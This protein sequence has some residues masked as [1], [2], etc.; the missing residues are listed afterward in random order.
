MRKVLSL[1]SLTL[2]RRQTIRSA[3]LSTFSFLTF[4]SSLHPFSP[5][6]LL[7][8]RLASPSRP[9][10]Y[11]L[12]LNR[13]AFFVPSVMSIQDDELMCCKFLRSP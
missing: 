5:I 3:H 7:S 1:F 10:H 2:P 8:S 4:Q 11:T 6:P 12:D 9:S 13:E